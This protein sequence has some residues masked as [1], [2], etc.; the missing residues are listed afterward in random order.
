MDS[1]RPFIRGAF[2]STRTLDSDPTR[3]SQKHRHPSPRPLRRAWVRAVHITQIG[4]T[5]RTP[6]FRYFPPKGLAATSLDRDDFGHIALRFLN[7]DPPT[8]FSHAMVVTDECPSDP[9]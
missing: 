1:T 8:G 7:L 3:Y 2:T 4:N 5:R 6:F 9:G